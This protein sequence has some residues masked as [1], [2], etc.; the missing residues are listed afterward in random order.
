MKSNLCWEEPE[1]NRQK[2]PPLYKSFGY[3]FEG[4]FAVV[5]KERNMKIHCCMMFLVI[6]AGFFF[7]I[8][9]VEWCICFVLFGLIMSLE[10]VNTA[11]E[12]VVDMVTRERM[13]LAKLAKDAAAG[14]VLIASIMAA[15]AGLII[16]IP[17]G[18]QFLLYLAG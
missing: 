16:F 5:K 4:I 11:V 18:W 1:M 15:A 12:S 8:S 6:L 14:A 13:P 17:K 9:A 2:K 7:K 10:L 3:A